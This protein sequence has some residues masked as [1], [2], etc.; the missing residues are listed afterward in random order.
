MKTNIKRLGA[1]ITLMMAVLVSSSA[2]TDDWKPKCQWPFLYKTF[3]R[4][5]VVTGIFKQTETVTPCNI[6]V[7]KGMLWFS[8]DNETLMEAVPDN[9]RKV[10][11]DNGDVYMPVHDVFGKVIYEGELQGKPA[12]VF[13]VQKV[14]QREVDQQHLDYLNT[15]QNV[16]QGAG[17]TFFSHLADANSIQKPEEMDVPMTNVFYYFF[18]GELFEATTTNILA[19]IDPS[20]KKEYKT[21]TRSAEVLSTSQKSML[22]VWNDFFVNY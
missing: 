8:K 9:I 13:L 3:R 12:R 21:Y 22:K 1:A 20:R 10:T 4:A 7:G 17:G 16:L 14:N 2:Q 18:K 15:T 6:H 19:H 11:F 5:T